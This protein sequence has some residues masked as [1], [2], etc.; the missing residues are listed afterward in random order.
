MP[1]GSEKPIAFASKS[2][3]KSQEGY[4]QIDKE[5]LS[6]IWAVKKFHYYLM[7]KEFTLITDHK[8]LV[9]IFSPDKG[10]PVMSA[11]RLQR[12]AIIL[13]AYKY[14]IEYKNT[15]DHANADCFSRLPMTNS[16]PFENG[17]DYAIFFTLIK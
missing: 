15:K 14:K 3:A 7:G 9:Y 13:S 10:I 11:A 5:A 6:I 8:P 16:E 4:S 12:Y 2:L 17:V 1:D